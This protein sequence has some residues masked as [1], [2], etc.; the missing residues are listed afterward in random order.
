[1]VLAR[2]W[3]EEVAAGA[4]TLRLETL[5]RLGGAEQ[6][7]RTHLDQALSALP[8]DDQEIASR[9]FHYLVTPSGTKIAHTAEDLAGYAAAPEAKAAAVLESLAG[10]S[11]ILRPV[12]NSSYEIYH[13][14]LAPAILEW[15]T[16]FE[17]RR[18]EQERA[19]R[20]RQRRLIFLAACLAATALALV[21]R[22][23]NIQPLERSTFDTRFA[24]RGA[25]AAP[26]NVVAVGID[27]ATFAEVKKSWPFPR[28][29]HAKVIDQLR[30]AG[31]RVIVYDVQFTEPTDAADDNAL[32]T[33]VG[34]AAGKIVLATTEVDANG[35]TTV[36][37]GDA[38]L[39]KIGARAGNALLP[40]D[41]GG[42]SRRLP[43]Q[44]DGLQS[45]SVVGAEVALHRR[46]TR[47][48]LGGHNSTWI[49]YVGPPGHVRT[50]SFWRV[51]QGRFDPSA[52]RGRIVVVGASAPS[53]GDVH[54]TP[55][56]SSELMSGAELQANAVS[57]ALRDFPLRNAAEVLSIALIAFLG[58]VV[59]LVSLRL[60]T[61]RT[62]AVG[63]AVGVAFV[64]AVQLAFNGGLV[65]PVVYP[66]GLLVVAV[67]A[68]LGLDA[69]T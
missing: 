33:A 60:S 2:L 9:L 58:L 42:V 29:L 13:D 47:A 31:A 46:I 63:I 21:A 34:R 37:G 53:L 3:S 7:V 69:G 6:I 67:V 45:L 19:R 59:P 57:T 49:D 11:R 56:A 68:S 62:L 40:L 1:L 36:L 54:A 50:L 43:Y 52:V 24:I 64:V 27:D 61:N 25:D 16:R 14:V 20:R 48:N 51:L 35:H 12:G 32:F 66:L 41:A 38:N 5:Q 4:G 65:L 55:F 17:A 28:S 23:F 30:K 39:H 10:E 26:S 18:D 15:R 44:T 8:F 22:S